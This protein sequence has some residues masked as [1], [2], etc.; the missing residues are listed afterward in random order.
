MALDRNRLALHDAERRRG[1]AHAQLAFA[2]G[3]PGSGL[4]E[5]ALSFAGVAE[6][7][8]DLP[9]DLTRRQAL[10]NR[11]DILSALATYAASESALRLE[12]AKQYPDLRFSPGYKY[13][14]GDNKWSL[15]LSLTLP[16]LDQN[17]G[18]IAEAEWKRVRSPGSRCPPSNWS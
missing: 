14:Q 1:E 12:V 4:D 10:L 15:G 11:A 16:V 17:Q 9:P 3:I 8:P 5:A 18:A 7:P 13:D 6:M 2:I